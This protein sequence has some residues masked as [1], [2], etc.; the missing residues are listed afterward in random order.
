MDVPSHGDHRTLKYLL[1]TL[2]STLQ[3][4]SWSIYENN[5]RTTVCNLR[6]SESAEDRGTNKTAAKNISYKKKSQAQIKRDRRRSELF[7][8]PKT[9]SQTNEDNSTLEIEN[10]RLPDI[11]TDSLSYTTLV[12]EVELPTNLNPEDSPFHVS[13]QQIRETNHCT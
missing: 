8:R 5:L 3:L 12:H 11:S 10:E 7:H 9:R 1:D 4:K 2:F 13:P 6:F